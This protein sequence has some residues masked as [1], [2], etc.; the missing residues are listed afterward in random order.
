VRNISYISSITQGSATQSLYKYDLNNNRI[1]QTQN[2]TETRY[3]IDQL[4]SLPNVVAETDNLGNISRYYIYGEGLVSQIDSNNNSHYYHYDPTGH[5]LA[6]SD[7]SGNVTDKYGYAP[8]GLTTSQGTTHN[9]FKYVGKHGVMDDGNG[10]HY[11]R[12]RYYKEDIKRFL[13][14]DALHGEMMSPQ[15]LNRYAYVLGNPVM[16]G[17]P[18]GNETAIESYDAFF[19][20]YSSELAKQL[21]KCNGIVGCTAA[22]KDNLDYAVAYS[23]IDMF[24]RPAVSVTSNVIEKDGWRA[25]L[26]EDGFSTAMNLIPLGKLMNA[27]KGVVLKELAKTKEILK[28]PVLR[29]KLGLSIGQVKKIRADLFRIIPK[30]GVE[31]KNIGEMQDLLGILSN[32]HVLLGRGMGSYKSLKN[33]ETTRFDCQISTGRNKR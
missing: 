2:G 19:E 28:S 12:A 7:E 25:I 5:T 24:I 32:I 29:K 31:A 8:Y 20:E 1:S 6:L 16:G 3:V 33:D 21:A 27:T 22:Y 4:A 10:L 17:D 26:S 18:S 14:L 9:P 23:V 15:S 11:M 30:I 13:S